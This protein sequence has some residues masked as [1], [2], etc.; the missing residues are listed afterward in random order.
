MEKTLIVAGIGE[1]LF[2]VL[3]EGKQLGG[4]PVNF[5]FHAKTLGLEAYPVSAVGQDTDG[6]DIIEKLTQAGFSTESIE[7]VDYPTGTAEVSLDADGIP[8]FT[9]TE[10][11]AW[12]HIQWTDQ[13]RALAKKVD[14]VCF[15]SLAQR[16]MHT[17][18]SIQRFLQQTRDDCLRIFDI[19]LRQQYYSRKVLDRSLQRANVLKLNDDELTVLQELLCLPQSTQDALRVLRDR[20]ELQYIALTRGAKGSVLMDQHSCC[21]CP[22]FPTTII[23]TV[24]AGDSYTAVLAYGIL[25]QLPLVRI[26]QVAN[27]VAAYVCSQAGATPVL[28]DSLIAEITQDL[29]TF[30]KDESK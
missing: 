9:I 4:A 25:H 18:E 8:H 30:S 11:V 29:L 16:S 12:D 7:Q 2:D 3:P 13:M 26:N 17:S 28:P 5:T 23:D 21:D 14:A 15:G 20:Y 1:I 19:N 22:S 24:G 10:N 27:Q 6:Q